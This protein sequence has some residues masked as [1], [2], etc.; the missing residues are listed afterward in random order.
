ML[1][2]SSSWTS[3]I[4]KMANSILTKALGAS[5]GQG[6]DKYQLGLTKIFFRAGMFSGVANGAFFYLSYPR[7]NTDHHSQRRKKPSLTLVNHFN[8][9]KSSFHNCLNGDLVDGE[10]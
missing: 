2:P 9:P 6:L 4:R 5:S 10:N 3:E 8:H 7:G 1:V